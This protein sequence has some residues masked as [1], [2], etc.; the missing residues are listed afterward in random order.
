MN[1]NNETL[2]P[3]N[4]VRDLPEALERIATLEKEVDDIKK[5]FLSR[6]EFAELMK[7]AFETYRDT[8]AENLKP[9]P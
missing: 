3:A 7:S 6:D 5:N 4:R 2:I 8:V 9:K 1:E